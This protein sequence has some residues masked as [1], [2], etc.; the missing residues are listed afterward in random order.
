MYKFAGL[1]SRCFL[2]W[3]TQHGQAPLPDPIPGVVNEQ[4]LLE[5]L[6]KA[7]KDHLESKY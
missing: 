4:L 7:R 6:Q 3:K 2:S 1:H 5:N